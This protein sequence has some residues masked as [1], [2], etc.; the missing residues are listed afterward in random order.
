MSREWL[1]LLLRRMDAVYRLVATIS[2]GTDGLSTR[3]EF[4]RKGRFDATIALH[5]GRD[6][7]VVRQGLA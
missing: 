5:D 3:V 7:G 6:F 2:P 1:T 4:H